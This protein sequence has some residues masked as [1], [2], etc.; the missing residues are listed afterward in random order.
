MK[1]GPSPKWLVDRLDHDETHVHRRGREFWLERLGAGFTLRRF[2]GI[3]R[4]FA[5]DRWYLNVVSR[6]TRRVTP[7]I[8]L[9]AE[10][11]EGP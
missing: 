5:L 9:V 3:W 10:R 7:A 2:T 8:L 4:Y 11:T 6:T 1:V